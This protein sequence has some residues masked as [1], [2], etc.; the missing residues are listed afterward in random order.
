MITSST[1]VLSFQIKVRTITCYTHS[2]RFASRKKINKINKKKVQIRLPS[3]HLN[4]TID[5]FFKIVKP[6]SAQ[7]YISH[8]DQWFDLPCKWLVSTWNASLGW[9]GLKPSLNIFIWNSTTNFCSAYL[10]IMHHTGLRRFCQPS[11][12]EWF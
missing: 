9:N 12:I 10:I 4:H 8:R 2:F 6:I 3:P 7:C 11:K 5:H 1:D